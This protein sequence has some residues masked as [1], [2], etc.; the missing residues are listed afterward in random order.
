M[1][2]GSLQN[3]V[4]QSLRTGNN[5]DGLVRE[6][7]PDAVNRKEG[8]SLA[9]DDASRHCM[10]IF[11]RRAASIRGSL[12]TWR[13]LSTKPRDE[14]LEE[15]EEV[16][17]PSFWQGNCSRKLWK[18]SC[19]RTALNPSLPKN[20]RVL[21]A[22]LAPSP[23]TLTVLKSACRIWEDHLWAQISIMCEEKENMELMKLGDSFWEGGV[24]AVE[25]GVKEMPAVDAEREEKE[26]VKEVTETSKSLKDVVVW[27]AADHAFHFSQLYIILNRMSQL[28]EAFAS[29]LS[30][31]YYGREAIEYAQ[32]V[33]S[34][35]I[36]ALTPR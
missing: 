23:Q 1:A 33:D 5:R 15:D 8:K 22:A 13:A 16:E 28:L 24:E 11:A 14:E 18:T 31:R 21:Y 29:G 17:E 26:W 36:C 9:S 35:R 10:G 20:E 2:T 27:K 34:S 12:F 19:T 3:S 25:K 32:C 7:D 4:I 6:M 30:N